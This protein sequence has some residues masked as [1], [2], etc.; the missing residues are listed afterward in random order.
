M[1]KLQLIVVSAA[2]LLFLGL[3][4][5]ASTKTPEQVKIEKTRSIVSESTTINAL[6]LDA[7]PQLDAQEASFIQAFEQSII[8][9]P[10]DSIKIEKYKELSGKWY[11]YNRAD[12][13]GYYAEQVALLEKTEDSW[14]ITGTTYLLGMR[15]AKAAK[16]RAFCSDRAVKAFE[17]AISLNP[18]NI[19]HKV[20]LASCYAENPPK[21]NPMKGILML[22]ELNKEK[23]ENTAVLITLARFGIQTGQ[24]DKAIERLKKAIELEPENGKAICLLAKAYDAIA[25]TN[26]ADFYSK[27]C[28]EYVSN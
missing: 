8:D 9:S 26:E 15:Q 27:K 5:G 11:E 13:A 2:I 17:S 19:Q 20:N 3:F 14:S 25:Q 12:I 21:D 16:N 22:L 23:P 24:Y 6:L 10:S 1:T 28:A 7:K 18:D 4:F